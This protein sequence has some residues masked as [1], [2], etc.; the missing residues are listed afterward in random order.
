MSVT[1]ISSCRFHTFSL[2]RILTDGSVYENFLVECMF[3][4][5]CDEETLFKKWCLL[6]YFSD[7]FNVAPEDI[8]LSLV[9]YC[10]LFF[11]AF[12]LLFGFSN[13]NNGIS[14]PM[15]SIRPQPRQEPD[16]HMLRA[17]QLMK[18]GDLMSP[19]LFTFTH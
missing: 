3:F 9:P 14:R 2:Y 7:I 11:P 13:K 1:S 8:R 6:L 12:C 10:D 17:Q 4:A 5:K 19:N 16:R 15:I 18:A